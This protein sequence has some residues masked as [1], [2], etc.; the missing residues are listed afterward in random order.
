MI[1]AEFQPEQ[2]SDANVLAIETED[3]NWEQ[4]FPSW[5]RAALADGTPI[6]SFASRAGLDYRIEIEQSLTNRVSK[7]IRANGILSLWI[8]RK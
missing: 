4:F 1:S 5:M 2:Y 3:I 6:P 7:S 8:C